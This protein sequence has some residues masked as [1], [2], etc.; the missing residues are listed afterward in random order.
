MGLSRPLAHMTV[1]HVIH[2]DL[3]LFPQHTMAL[4]THILCALINLGNQDAV[5]RLPQ[6]KSIQGL[7]KFVYGGGYSDLVHNCHKVL[8]DAMNQI[9]P[10]HVV[11]NILPREF[12]PEYMFFPLGT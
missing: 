1:S 6:K 11:P 5:P 2:H 9:D 12:N 8:T 10:G 3:L 7:R 4:H